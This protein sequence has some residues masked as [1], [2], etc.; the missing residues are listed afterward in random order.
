V[1]FKYFDMV[2]MLKR[3]ANSTKPPFGEVNLLQPKMRL[4]GMNPRWQMDWDGFITELQAAIKRDVPEIPKEAMVDETVLVE[5][6][7]AE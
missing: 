7:A 3:D 2:I 1:W 4:Q 5:E 6:G